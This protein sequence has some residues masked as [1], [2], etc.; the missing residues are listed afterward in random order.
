VQRGVF[1]KREDRKKQ[2]KHLKEQKKSNAR[3]RLLAERRR[4]DLYPRIIIDPKGGDPEFVSIVRR[5]LAGFSFEDP[6]ICPP[7]RQRI[8]REFHKL[9]VDQ[10][11]VNMQAE[12]SEI[13]TQTATTQQVEDTACFTIHEYLGN[14]IF[15]RLPEPCR[16]KPLPFHYYEAVPSTK[17]LVI[18]FALLPNTTNEHGRI[19]YSGF[20]PTVPFGG[21]KWKVAFFRHAI[22]RICERLCTKPQINFS[23]FSSL[24]TY[25]R[26]TTYFEP[27]ELPDGQHAIRLFD[28]CYR[29]DDVGN[30][31]YVKHVLENEIPAAQNAHLVHVLG[32]CPLSFIGPRAVAKTFLYPGYRNTPEDHL[33]RTAPITMAKRRELLA[34]A[35]HNNATNFYVAGGF[36]AIKWYHDNGVPQ[37]IALK[38]ELSRLWDKKAG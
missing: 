23:H 17:D 2:K 35:S 37:V 20:Q 27:L 5:I 10:M 21:G 9:G 15:E 11:L 24:A 30:H 19:Y 18:R 36:E 6:T 38:R 8:F 16:V 31:P 22:E 4:A 13:R 1:M 34:L 14:W 33:V 3:Q 28:Y 25:F 32:Y 12:L 26:F 29:G 7:D